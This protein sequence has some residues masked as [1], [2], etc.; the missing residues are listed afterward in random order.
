MMMILFN[1]GIWQLCTA[2][3]NAPETPDN[4]V[5]EGTNDLKF[6]PKHVSSEKI[7]SYTHKV[8]AG[9][10][11]LK[12]SNVKDSNITENGTRLPT[13]L[14]GSSCDLEVRSHGYLT[15]KKKI[16]SPGE[17]YECIAVDCFAS[18]TRYS[19]I[20]LRVVL[21]E[22]EFND[23][24]TSKSW[25]SPDLFVVSRRSCSVFDIASNC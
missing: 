3:I 6:T 21:P 7:T 19:D 15:T 16:P 22:N 20:A 13:W 23:Q 24:N 17:L 12:V 18:E 4:E 1:F 2:S 5:S 8:K 11:C 14:P 9:S 10:S 25:K